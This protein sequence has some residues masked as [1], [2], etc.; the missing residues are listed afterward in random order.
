MGVEANKTQD[1]MLVVGKLGA[2]YGIRGW[3]KVFH[4][5]RCL[6]AYSITNLGC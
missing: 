5:Q 1:G 6:R 4:T 2:S 3:I